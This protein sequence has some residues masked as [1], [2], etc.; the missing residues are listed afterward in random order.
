[1]VKKN[2]SILLVDP[3]QDDAK[4]LAKALKEGGHSVLVAKDAMH[5]L[6]ILEH[7][8]FDALIVDLAVAHVQDLDLIS[9]AN[10]ICPKP[11]VVAIAAASVNVEQPI[12]DR[13]ASLLLHKPV[14]TEKLL[15]FLAQAQT[16]SSFSGNVEGVDIIEYV[17]FV[18]LGGG[19]TILQITSSVGTAGRLFI[20]AGRVVHAVCGVL[21]GEQALYR[22]LGFR[23]GTFSHLPW[24]EPEE[25]TIKKAGEFILM[26]AIRKRD[27]A[28]SS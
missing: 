25:L 23:E 12:L 19:R 5:A 14:D 11:R 28:W 24:S 27:E 7:R 22:C 15:K 26:E 18:L 6:S 8:G 9:W 3:D 17:Q 13:G 16:R 1:M 21:Q 10:C 2:C 20:S 4:S